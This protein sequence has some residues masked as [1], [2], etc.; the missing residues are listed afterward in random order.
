MPGPFSASMR[1]TMQ[2]HSPRRRVI[3]RILA[4]AGLA[5]LAAGWALVIYPAAH[6]TDRVVTSI[7]VALVAGGLVLIP[8]GLDLLLHPA[9]CGRR[10]VGPLLW[11]MLPSGALFAITVVMLPIGLLSQVAA[12]L[13]E[14]V[15]MALYGRAWW[16]RTHVPT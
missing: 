2:R 1:P 3:V 14:A 5:L 6:N 11:S 15:G 12:V 16:L 13:A 8:P 9:P 10:S 7:A 4:F